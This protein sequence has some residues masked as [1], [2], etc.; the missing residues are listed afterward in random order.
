M[1][2]EAVNLDNFGVLFNDSNEVLAWETEEHILS[3]SIH[4]VYSK[5]DLDLPIVHVFSLFLCISI[6]V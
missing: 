6:D 2:N 1:L 3:W 4:L 5:S